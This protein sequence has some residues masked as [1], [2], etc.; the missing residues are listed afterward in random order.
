MA[1]ETT[2]NDFQKD[3][4]DSDLPVLVDFWAPWCGPCKLVGPIMDRLSDKAGSKA[5]I[6]KM[7]V[8]ENPSVASRYGI[9]AI[10][11]VLLFRNGQVQQQLIGVQPEKVYEKALGL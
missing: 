1:A 10:P 11:T 4:L 2:D 8:D 6:L 5:K 9:T 3:V 7:N